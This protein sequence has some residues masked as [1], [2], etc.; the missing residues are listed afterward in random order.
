MLK[1]FIRR[2]LAGVR[3][4]EFARAVGYEVM[5]YNYG[6]FTHLLWR[7]FGKDWLPSEF[8]VQ[9]LLD[10][11]TFFW[12]SRDQRGY[13]WSL[14]NEEQ[15]LARGW[16]AEQHA[17][18]QL[19]ASVTWCASLTAGK[20]QEEVRFCLRDVWREFLQRPLFEAT[21]GEME[22]AWRSLSVLRP[23]MTPLPSEIVETLERLA[24]FETP[25]SFLRLMERL[26]DSRPYSWHFERT[27]VAR[28]GSHQPVSVVC[29]VT[30]ATRALGSHEDALKVLHRWMAW[31]ERDYYRIA[32]P[33][34]NNAQQLLFWDRA[35]GSGI[36][37]SSRPQD[38]IVEFT[39]VPAAPNPDLASWRTA[40]EVL[41]ERITMPVPP[42]AV[43]ATP[44]AGHPQ[45]RDGALQSVG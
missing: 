16:L 44:A 23:Y 7:L 25:D 31:E 39:Q 42:R 30:P 43:H 6:I 10:T 45:A 11:W 29:L 4:P 24:A 36:Y 18:G 2:Y 37:R 8:I 5:V 21:A 20:A 19:L 15:A 28:E 22:V 1:A 3:N 38:P 33:A 12:G 9:A 14:T 17:A 13:F 32:S 41:E 35:A 27:R 26:Y 34:A 40:A